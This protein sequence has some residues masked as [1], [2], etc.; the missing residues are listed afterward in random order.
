M[1]EANKEI[2]EEQDSKGSGQDNGGA[3]AVEA[4]QLQTDKIDTILQGI[5][6]I[7]SVLNGSG[8]TTAIDTN[9]GGNTAPNN[10]NDTNSKG[11]DN[12]EKRSIKFR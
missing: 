1:D 6:D 4:T 3:S 7:M 10:S 11:G 2:K 8:G 12:N 5:R 9:N